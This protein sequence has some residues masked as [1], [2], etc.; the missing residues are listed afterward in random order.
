[1]GLSTIK[2]CSNIR[3]SFVKKL[4]E[5]QGYS[6]KKYSAFSGPISNVVFQSFKKFYTYIYTVKFNCKEFLKIKTIKKWGSVPVF[7][8]LTYRQRLTFNKRKS[9]NSKV[10]WKRTSTNSLEAL[11]KI[12]LHFAITDYTP[13]TRFPSESV[14][15]SV[16]LKTSLARIRVSCLGTIGT[17]N[18]ILKWQYQGCSKP[19]DKN[20]IETQIDRYVT[21][22]VTLKTPM[23]RERTFYLMCKLGQSLLVSEKTQYGCCPPLIAFKANTQTHEKLIFVSKKYLIF[24]IF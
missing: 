23:L 10:R 4:M 18:W 24:F 7:I 1:M 20:H 2:T 19:C 11:W 14:T 15:T 8:L 3:V 17:Q 9:W 12:Q 5:M 6:G 16:Y 13:T 22:I 21:A